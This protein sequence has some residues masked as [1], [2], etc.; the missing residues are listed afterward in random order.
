MN[1]QREGIDLVEFWQFSLSDDPFKDY[2]SNEKFAIQMTF[3][4]EHKEVP[5]VLDVRGLIKSYES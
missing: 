2:S 3:D 4:D 1:Q 5:I